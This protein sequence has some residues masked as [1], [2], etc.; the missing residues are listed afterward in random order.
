MEKNKELNELKEAAE[1]KEEA[2]RDFAARHA[3]A[4]CLNFAHDSDSDSD[5]EARS[6][7][8]GPPHLQCSRY[9]RMT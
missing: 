4:K 2:L 5:E 8:A 1:K 6:R 3:H 7:P 9:A